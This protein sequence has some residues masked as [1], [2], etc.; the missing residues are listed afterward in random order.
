VG[1]AWFSISLTPEFSQLNPVFWSM[2][3][4][5]QARW[6]GDG[7]VALLPTLGVLSFITATVMTIALW[8]FN[9]GMVVG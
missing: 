5:S 7:L 8:R 1:S 2:E 9:R 4:F 3:G 6:D